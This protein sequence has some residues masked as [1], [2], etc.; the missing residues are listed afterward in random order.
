MA[1]GRGVV[2][3]D[4]LSVR[5]RSFVHTWE[6]NLCSRERSMVGVRGAFC[7]LYFCFR[8]LGEAKE[9]MMMDG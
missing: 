3:V 2:A 6:S 4:N 5:D 1:D 7:N 8:S 9:K